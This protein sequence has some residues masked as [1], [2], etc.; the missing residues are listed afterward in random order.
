MSNTY[1]EKQTE[2]TSL[3]ADGVLE[4]TAME[5][6]DFYSKRIHCINCKIHEKVYV[7]MGVLIE[8]A[9]CPICGCKALM[10]K[11]LDHYE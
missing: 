9:E 4:T 6:S 1:T 11:R 10:I 2:H 5:M 8:D 7:R 3:R